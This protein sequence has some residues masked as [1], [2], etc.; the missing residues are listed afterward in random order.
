[1]ANRTRKALT[2]SA[3]RR[4]PSIQG[5]A[6]TAGHRVGDKVRIKGG[7]HAGVRAV[8]GKVAH[9]LLIT[10]IN[11]S[12]ALMVPPGD[13][14][15]YSL[16][17][18]RAWAVMPKR[19]GRPKKAG[20]TKRMVSIRIDPNVWDGLA[21]MVRAGRIPSREGA[22]N[23]WLRTHLESLRAQSSAEVQPS[24]ITHLRSRVSNRR[25]NGKRY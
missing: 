9:N 25:T 10:V 11:G 7:V 14:T 21:A 12:D 2:K 18:R 5:E 1:M 6:S 23:A 3:R 17:A 20:S 15:N 16:A 4:V 13:V 19:S 22:L 8:V 24:T